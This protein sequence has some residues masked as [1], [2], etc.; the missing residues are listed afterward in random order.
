MRLSAGE[1]WLFL[2]ASLM[3]WVVKL[4]L[5]VLPFETLRRYLDKL[6]RLPSGFSMSGERSA[7]QVV[8]AVELAGRLMPRASTCLTQALSAQVLLLRRGYPALV[9]IGTVR[10]ERGEF[11][12]HAWVESEDEVVLGGDELERYTRLT[13]LGGASR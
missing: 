8:W 1:R 12:A 3:L 10:G 6:V 9:H 2:K 4:G 7:D 11:E 5:I 13:V